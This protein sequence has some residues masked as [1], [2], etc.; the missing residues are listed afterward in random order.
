[1]GYS[2]WNA[3]SDLDYYD[4]RGLYEE[5]QFSCEHCED[6]G[7]PECSEVELGCEDLALGEDGWAALLASAEDDDDT[8]DTTYIN[9]LNE[10][11]AESSRD[12][13]AERW[14][15]WA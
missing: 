4:S 5:E 11:S 14:E 8:A 10:R 12:F 6:H 7:C 2:I 15:R 3:P 1:M 13:Q 9:Y